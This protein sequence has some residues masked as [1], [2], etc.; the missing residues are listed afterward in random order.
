MQVTAIFDLMQSEN[1][2]PHTSNAICKIENVF[3]V[4]KIQN[5][6]LKQ[7]QKR[8]MQNAEKNLEMLIFNA[9]EL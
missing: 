9:C 2:M 8:R 3:F 6:K 7:K 5:V 1:I 4:Y